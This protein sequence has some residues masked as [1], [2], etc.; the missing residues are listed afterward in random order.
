MRKKTI[1][2]QFNHIIKWIDILCTICISIFK[3]LEGKME[4]GLH[5]QS[6]N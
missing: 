5:L 6:Q 1:N 4:F 2:W 3:H